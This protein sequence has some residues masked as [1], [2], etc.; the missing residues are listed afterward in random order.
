MAET[1]EPLAT[2]RTKRDFGASPEPLGRERRAPESLRFVVQEHHAR[3]LHWDLRLEHE[4][5]LA[6]WAI[7]KG[8]PVDPEQRRLAVHTEDHPLEYLDFH[9]DIPAGNYGAGTMTIWDSGTFELE[10]W[11]DD[12]VIVTFSG[13]RVR[14]KYVL[15]HTRGDNWMIH[16]MDPPEDP[17]REPPPH[18]RPMLATAA[19]ARPRGESWAYEVWWNGERTL[20]LVEGGRV[21][22]TDSEGTDVTETYPEVRE[23][24]SSLGA[25]AA[26]LDG[27][28]V[29]VGGNG[30]IDRDEL[31]ARRRATAAA[32]RRR[33]R[34]A[35]V[36]YMVFD[37]LWLDGRSLLDLP[38]TER[39][40]ELVEL[41]LSGPAWQTPP[42]EPQ[43]PRGLSDVVARY[44]LRG[45]V[46]KRGTSTYR[47]GRQSAE[48]RT[49][50]MR[51][52]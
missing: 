35:P 14:G 29:V 7:P 48:W 38:Y 26:L 45:V 20:A 39:R 21:T 41:G 9:G 31:D 43:E 3:S 23:L 1:R 4:G 22:L 30:R 37:L 16:R 5:V 10:K 52:R 49:V 51:W 6:S 47:P 33:S 18:V 34:D 17:D 50:P 2:Y 24:G 11:R 13:G 25:T 44:G 28:I 19:R 42:H 27:D 46:A 8:I 32:A 36:V 40:Q 15:F 12:E